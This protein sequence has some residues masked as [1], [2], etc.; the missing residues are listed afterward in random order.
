MHEGLTIALTISVV[1]LKPNNTVP[2]PE[3]VVWVYGT[4]DN[5]LEIKYDFTK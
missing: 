4:F 2:P 5:N 3:I 1:P